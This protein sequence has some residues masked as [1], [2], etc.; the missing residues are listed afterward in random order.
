MEELGRVRPETI[1]QL[2]VLPIDEQ[3]VSTLYTT[4]VHVHNAGTRY[5]IDSRQ[6]CNRKRKHKDRIYEGVDNIKMVPAS[7]P[8]RRDD[9]N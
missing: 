4:T 3:M 9:E 8:F 1:A 2:M 6:R 7:F 5:P